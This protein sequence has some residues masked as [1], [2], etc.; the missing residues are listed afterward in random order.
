MGEI[1]RLQGASELLAAEKLYT[2]AG[3]ARPGAVILAASRGEGLESLTTERPKVMLEV[4]GKPLLRRLV[5]LFKAEA[6]HDINVVGGYKAEAI[7]V[8]GIRLLHNPDYDRGGELTTLSCAL[9]AFGAD[10]VI[11]YGDLLFRSY[12]LRDLLNS[13]AP[14]TVVVDSAPL[15]ER[16]NQNDLAWCSSADDRAM[17]KIGRAHV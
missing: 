16:G 14:I 13:A 2:R 1:F 6:V 12:V 5:D 17:Y 3:Q 7:D 4:A 9:P 15:P 11:L 10:S 8:Q